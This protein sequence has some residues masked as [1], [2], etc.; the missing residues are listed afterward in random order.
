MRVVDR[1]C[2][3]RRSTPRTSLPLAWL[4][5][6]AIVALAGADG[7]DDVPSD[8][9]FS[10]LKIDGKTVVGRLR[11][12]DVAGGVSLAVGEKGK[13]ETVPAVMLVKL[14]REGST[15]ATTGGTEIVLFPDGDRLTCREIGPAGETTLEV[16]SPALGTLAIPLDSILGLVL[17]PRLDPEA[18][19]AIAS[20][21]RDEPRTTEVLWLGNG[22]RLA[23]GLLG[24]DEKKVAFQ[25]PTGKAEFD[26]SGLVALGFDPKLASYPKPGGPYIELTFVDGSRI[27][28]AD[29]RVEGGEI[30]ATTRAGQAIKLPVGELAQAHA[31]GGPVAYLSDRAPDIEKNVGYVGPTRPARMNLAIDGQPLRLGGKAYDRGLGTQSRSYLLYRLEPGVKRFQALVGVDDR[32]GPLGSV[33]F[34][35]IVDGEERFVSPAMSVR[36]TPKAIDVDLSGAKTLVL[37]TDFGERGEVRDHADW[38]EA[39]LIR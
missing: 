30:R 31:K 37:R 14:T 2:S 9:V 18:A 32:A 38:V 7:P 22:D 36:D 1:S 11:Q 23:G 33:T 28:V 10:A 19:Q 8:P 6:V 20:R 27:G 29:L 24:L 25:L 16:N 13:V 4:G 35:V 15:P 39:R 12:L 17:A 34:S 5:L 21:V 3:S 26:R